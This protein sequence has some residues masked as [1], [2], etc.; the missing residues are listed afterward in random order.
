MI[1]IIDREEQIAAALSAFK[2][3]CYNPKQ[4]VLLLSEQFP[5]TQIKDI[6]TQYLPLGIEVR[7]LH[8]M[9]QYDDTWKPDARYFI[10]PTEDLPF[11]LVEKA[12]L[13]FSYLQTGYGVSLNPA[14]AFRLGEDTQWQN[15]LFDQVRL[16]A[17]LA[18]RKQG[19]VLKKLYID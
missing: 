17:V 18:A 5:A 15:T 12:V 6:Y 14:Q 11:D 7:S 1:Y 13:H 2:V 16:S 10:F 3:V 19:T 9:E 4:C 8:Y